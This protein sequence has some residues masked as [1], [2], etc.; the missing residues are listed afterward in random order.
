[1]PRLTALNATMAKAIVIETDGSAVLDWSGPHC[2]TASASPA[3]MKPLTNQRTIWG[4]VTILVP[5][6]RGGR[7][8]TLGS[9]TS[10]MN[11]TTTVTTTKNLQNSSCIGNSATPP[12]M[13]KMVARSMSWSTD[14][15]T[16]SWSF[17]YEVM[18]R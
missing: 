14:D 2:N 4:R 13:L 10:T 6:P 8:M 17:T 9:G 18:R 16:V 5:G 11:P 15:K 7:C 3:M 1:M 12:L